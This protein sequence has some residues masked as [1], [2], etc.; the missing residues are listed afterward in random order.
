VSWLSWLFSFIFG[1]PVAFL[2]LVFDG[3]AR[4]VFS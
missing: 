1:V 3:H 4:L 2:G